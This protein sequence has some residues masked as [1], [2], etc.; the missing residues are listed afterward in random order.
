MQGGDDSRGGDW[1][2]SRLGP[3]KMSQG[4]VVREAI[5]DGL[6]DGPCASQRVVV[7]VLVPV[8]V[9]VVGTADVG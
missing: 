5:V 7:L 9:P 3:R 4:E 6:G 8:A 1:V 2:L